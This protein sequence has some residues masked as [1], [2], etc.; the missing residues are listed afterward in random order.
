MLTIIHAQ[1]QDDLKQIK[2]LFIEYQAF[3][4][5]NLHFQYFEQELKTLPHPYSPP[6]GCLLLGVEGQ[7]AA[8]CVALKKLSAAICEMKR[9]YVRPYFRRR[10]YGLLLAEKIIAE[11]R[12]LGYE[13]VRLDTL[14]RLREAMCLYEK[15]GFIKTDAY[16]DNP[17]PDVIYWQLDL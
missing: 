16:Y 11:A 10:G 12:R 14:A 5:V 2:A 8:G 9:L 4:K 7:A 13:K 15:L 1:S 6:G 17:L 3:L